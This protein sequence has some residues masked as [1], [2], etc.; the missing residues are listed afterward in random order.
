MPVFSVKIRLVFSERS[1]LNVPGDF[2]LELYYSVS[3]PE[4]I[5]FMDRM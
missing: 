4:V 3:I 1:S 5:V 2:E